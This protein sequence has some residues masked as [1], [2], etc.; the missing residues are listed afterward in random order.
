[1]AFIVQKVEGILG[2]LAISVSGT[3]TETRPTT[4]VTASVAAAVVSV[5]LLALNAA[6]RG[7][8]VFNDSTADLFVKLGA[9]AS[10]TSFTVR[11][12]AG[13]S[14]ELPYPVYTGVID[15]IWE[16]AIGAARVTELT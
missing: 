15:G 16:A 2:G 8:V 7:A 14:Y 5:A 3:F 11:V 13:G 4:G 1:M 12:S 6:R 9:T 10:L